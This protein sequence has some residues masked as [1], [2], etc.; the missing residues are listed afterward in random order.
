MLG[1]AF[2]E[3]DWIEGFQWPERKGMQ[4]SKLVG[5]VVEVSRPI[6]E[7]RPKKSRKEQGMG[8]FP[9]PNIWEDFGAAA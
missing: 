7:V 9:A 5:G 6:S 3:R 4:G 8:E 1:E 2:Q